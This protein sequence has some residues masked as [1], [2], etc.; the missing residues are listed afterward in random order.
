MDRTLAAV[1]ERIEQLAMRTVIRDQQAKGCRVVDVSADRCGWHITSYSLANV[2]GSQPD[3]LH[4]EPKCANTLTV[5]RTEILYTI[6][7]G[8]KFELAIVFVN[9]DD[10]TERPFYIT[11]P[12]QREP[13]CGPASVTY[14]IRKLL[15]SRRPPSAWGQPPT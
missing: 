9:P 7:Q 11:N 4:I 5:T 6:N 2:G 8:N 3:P 14:N 15:A 12:L 1:R 13:D 10:S